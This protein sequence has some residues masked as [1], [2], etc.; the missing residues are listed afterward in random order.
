MFQQV[1]VFALVGGIVTVAGA[2]TLHVPGQYPTIQAAMTAAVSGDTVLVADGTYTGAGNTNLSFF[3]KPIT[4]RSQSGPET[5]IIDCGGDSVAFWLSGDPPEAIIDGFTITNGGGYPGGGL[6]MYYFGDA[7]IRNCII[8]G[9]ASDFAGGG[10][11]LCEGACPTFINCT[12]TLNNAAVAGGGGVFCTMSSPTFRNCTIAGNGTGGLGGAI[13]CTEGSFPTFVNSIIWGNGLDQIHIDDFSALTAIHSD[14]Q[15][16]WP[17]TGNIDGDPQFVDVANGDV[18]LASGAPPIDA[19]CNL[20]LMNLANTDLDGD[21]RFADDPGTVDTGCGM[22]V[23]VDMGAYEYQG[24]PFD[25]KLGDIDGDGVVG[26][27][28]LLALLAA[29]GPTRGPCALADLDLT[30]AVGTSDL[31]ILLG[32][33]G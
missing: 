15:G 17:G 27:A 4:V 6:Y 19:G 11:V 26:T 28:D 18:H 31:L 7:T 8:T 30:G 13:A 23:I 14:I 29:W 2:E 25:V 3:S 1:Q 33:W 10:G 16:G 21:F 24:I 22:P 5:C 20:G 9:N 32:S 12:I